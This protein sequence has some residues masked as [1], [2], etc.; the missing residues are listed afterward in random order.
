MYRFMEGWFLERGAVPMEDFFEGWIKGRGAE[1]EGYFDHLLSWWAV[2]EQ[3]NVLL[4]SYRK[5]VE[6]RAAHIRRLASFCG[7][8]LDDELL[9]L[10]LERTSRSWMLEHKNRFDD[11][12]MREKSETMGKLPS[13]SDSAKVRDSDGC[14]WDEI[15]P[16]IAMRIEESWNERITSVLGYA[17]FAALE[18][19]L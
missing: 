6:S 13:G 17:D 8:A 14:H 5:V 3:P 12:L 18:A 15:E 19:D 2:R 9:D 16:G 1:G 10:T 7:I 11:A 4:L